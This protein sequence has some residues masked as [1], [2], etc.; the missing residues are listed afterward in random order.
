MNKLK[1]LTTIILAAAA[2][3]S[4]SACKKNTEE[5][6][7][8]YNTDVYAM[9]GTE[10]GLITDD[11]SDEGLYDESDPIDNKTGLLRLKGSAAEDL[12]TSSR[13]VINKKTREAVKLNLD[14]SDIFCLSG[15]K[16]YYAYRVDSFEESYYTEIYEYDIATQESKMVYRYDATVTEL[17]ANGGK[18][19][20]YAE[21]DG[22]YCIDGDNE[23]HVEYKS[24]EY[25]SDMTVYK[26]CIY[27]V[28]EN[29]N[30]EDCRTIKCCSFDTGKITEIADDIDAS[31]CIYRI[32]DGKIYY[33]TGRYSEYEK[34]DSMLFG[35]YVVKECNLDSSGKKLISKY[36]SNPCEGI[37]CGKNELLYNE[38][39][40]EPEECEG[41]CCPDIDESQIV[42]YIMNLKTGKA[43]KLDGKINDLDNFIYTDDGIYGYVCDDDTITVYKINSDGKIEKA[44]E[45]K[46]ETDENLKGDK[47]YYCVD[48]VAY[49]DGIICYSLDY[50]NINKTD[51][52]LS[53]CKKT[54]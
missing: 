8:D 12:F 6:P 54:K 9:D 29:E 18:V 39:L 45:C 13:M 23:K 16:L 46:V 27:F 11:E 34:A 36:F 21:N 25:F 49:F 37:F 32:T 7:A 2:V 5:V 30:S 26:N 42:S 44:A 53:D 50:Y 51:F 22:F 33:V 48:D 14:Y 47:A 24:S 10:E 28:G 3:F 41:C 15:T 17:S 40:S 31:T 4:L 1:S 35:L 43:V 19:W 20:F 38:Y 52:G